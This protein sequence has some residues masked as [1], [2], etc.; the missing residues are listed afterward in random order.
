M[1]MSVPQQTQTSI[2]LK[3]LH[4]SSPHPLTRAS[5]DPALA[6]APGTLTRWPAVPMRGGGGYE[7]GEERDGGKRRHRQL[8]SPCPRTAPLAYAPSERPLP[9]SLS[10][11][12]AAPSTPFLQGV[13]LQ[14]AGGRWVCSPPQVAG[15][16]L[17]PGAIHTRPAS[18]WHAL[19]TVGTAEPSSRSTCH[20]DATTSPS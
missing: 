15:L 10:G 7:K 1:L 6:Q 13:L 9:A 4:V 5:S 14:K 20:P 3:W 2:T 17:Q 11:A 18:A 16:C 19:V 8:E 12:G